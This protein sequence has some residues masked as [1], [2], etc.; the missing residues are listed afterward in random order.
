[1]TPQPQSLF[2]CYVPGLD[3]R[4]IDRDKTPYIDSLRNELEAVSIRT[5]PNTELI[6][7][8]VSGTLPHQHRVWQVSLKPRFR[9]GAR[10]GIADA[11][12]DILVTTAQCTR[13]FFDREYDLAVI[14]WR[15]RRR[16]EL[17]RFKYT[18][19]AV[20]GDGMEE[21]SGYR[22]IFGL[23][24]ERAQY[25]FTK[26]FDSLPKLAESL[27]TGQR[28][29]EF[30]EMY[31]LDLV[32]H[33]HLDN[34][35]VMDDALLRTDRFVR[36]LHAR[37]RRLG[38]RLMLLVDHG[39]ERVMGTVPLVQTV[40][41]TGIPESEYSYFVE[42]ASA[43]FWFHTERARRVLSDV[44]KAL[45]RTELLTW[46]DMH[47]YDVCFEDDAFGEMYI[48]ADAGWIFFP[49]D[50]YQPVGNVVLGLMDRHQRQR[51]RN[52]VHRGNHGYLPHHPSERGWVL[53]D[54]AGLRASG[55]EAR[56][57]DIAPSILSLVGVTA[58]DY[59]QGTPLFLSDG[60]TVLHP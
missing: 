55:S 18:R 34:E 45:P 33:W 17:H 7:T 26:D 41:R 53:A 32:Q 51:V 21:F 56:L 23:L 37:C 4:R 11:V 14:P 22:S 59:M 60:N 10:P 31:A 9:N 44:L 3:A 49:H 1:M 29:L 35:D 24:G 28:A 38:V 15:R 8:L 2:V 39:Q 46:R 42:L 54:D 25:I 20:Q 47:D 30:L 19:R 43:R 50:F 36:D 27:P 40:K 12:P 5:L 58:P 16:F 48:F 6:P 57:A 13:H 52:P